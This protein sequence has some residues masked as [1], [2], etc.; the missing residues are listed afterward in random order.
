[1]IGFIFQVT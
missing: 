1:M